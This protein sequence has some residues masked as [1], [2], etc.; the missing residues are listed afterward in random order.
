[1]VIVDEAH[2]SVASRWVKALD[3]FVENP[4]VYLLGLT[5]T[6]GISSGI[7]NNNYL[8]STYYNSNKISITDNNYVEIESPIQY[9]VDREFLAQIE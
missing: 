1:M 8:L 4:S 2:R 5:A 7:D 3:F 9:L 6:P